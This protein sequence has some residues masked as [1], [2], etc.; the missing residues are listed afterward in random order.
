MDRQLDAIRS[1]QLVV[2]SMQ[3]RVQL[4]HYDL[5]AYVVMAND[6]H[7]LSLPNPT[8]SAAAMAN[9]LSGRTGEPFWQKEP[10]RVLADSRLY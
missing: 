3:R 4:A 10:S 5:H 6:V 9:R 8:E 1:G 2:N 7:L